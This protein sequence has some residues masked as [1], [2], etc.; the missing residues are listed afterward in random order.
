MKVAARVTGVAQ[1]SDWL[2][3]EQ[4]HSCGVGCVVRS[5]NQGVRIFLAQKRMR[6]DTVL[7]CS[8]VSLP[9]I[10]RAAF[11]VAGNGVAARRASGGVVNKAQHT[12]IS[13]PPVYRIALVQTVVLV[14]VAALLWLV[15][16]AWAAALFWGGAIEVLPRLYFGI[17]AFRFT[18]A[19]QMRQVVA[20]LRRGEMGKFVLVVTMFSGLFMLNKSIAPAA[21]F[22]GYFASWLLGMVLSARWLR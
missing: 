13:K 22:L 3:F 20:S 11:A 16:P 5:Q 14:V 9:Y 6:F 19:R 18:G 21:V 17:Y 1:Y 2:F 4:F 8:A 12:G 15:S 7:S 10:L